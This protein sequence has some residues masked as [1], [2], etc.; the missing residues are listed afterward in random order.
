MKVKNPLNMA[1][2]RS[3]SGRLTAMAV[4]SA[5]F[6]VFV[7]CTVLFGYLVKMLGNRLLLA[8]YLNKD[9]LALS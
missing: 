5:F 6:M 7:A 2:L 3:I 9:K 1:A 8:D 4:A